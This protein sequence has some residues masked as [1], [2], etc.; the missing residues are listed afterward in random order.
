MASNGQTEKK[1][2]LTVR[3]VVSV[4]LW[5]PLNYSVPEEMRSKVKIGQRALVPLNKRNVTGIIVDVISRDRC[6]TEIK[7]MKL[8]PIGEILDEQPAADRRLIKLTKWMTEYYVNRWERNLQLCLPRGNEKLIIKKI[9]ATEKLKGSTF[10]KSQDYKKLNPAQKQII[11]YLIS[12]GSTNIKI[13]DEKFGK[14]NWGSILQSLEKRGYVRL[15]WSLKSNQDLE[16]LNTFVKINDKLDASGSI[17]LNL[18]TKMWNIL[19]FLEKLGGEAPVST[20]SREFKNVYSTIN[21]LANKG[22]IVKEKRRIFRRPALPSQSLLK[23]LGKELLVEQQAAYAAIKR[24]L[25]SDKYSSFLLFG[26][27]GSGKTEIYLQVI[28]E[29]LRQN[30]QA[31]V[32]VPEIALTPQIIRRFTGRFGSRIAVI[33][34]R[35]SR[36]EKYDEWE[37][38]RKGEADIVIGARSALFAPLRNPGIIIVDEEQ[39][40]SYKQNSEPRYNARDLAVMRAYQNRCCVLLGS[41]TPSVESYYNG[42]TGKYTMLKLE[43]RVNERP[44]PDIRIIDM[45]KS[46]KKSKKQRSSLSQEMKAAMMKT[47]EQKGQIILLLNRRGYSTHIYCRHC[48]EGISCPHCSV[49]M[50]YHSNENKIMCHHCLYTSPAPTK[51]PRCSEELLEYRGMGIQK[52]EQE[53]NELFPSNTVLRM[54][55]DTVT[56]KNAYSDILDEFRH[57]KADIL[58]GTQMVAKGHDFAGVLLVG[59]LD[60]DIGLG[61]PN[62]RS[63]EQLFALLTQTAGR[64]GRGDRPG[65]CLIQTLCPDHYSVQFAQ[66]H[67]YKGFYDAELSLRKKLHMPPFSSLTL[68][69]LQSSNRKLVHHT[70]YDLKSE[71]QKHSTNLAA[72]FGPAPAPVFKLK[73]DYRWQFLIKTASRKMM[74]SYLHAIQP[75][76][77]KLDK[78]RN[79]KLVID[80]DPMEVF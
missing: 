47:L 71:L 61:I 12:F 52:L 15:S 18:S 4:P 57:G 55:R 70:A 41:A 67:D 66:K 75:L 28:S 30:R 33:H 44:L 24:E 1:N 11:D 42:L 63:A 65:R 45:N 29:V 26:V 77:R 34:S 13:I 14:K 37:R 19:E 76:L 64:T 21:R 38:I 9:T 8:E 17:D 74:T 31:L 58:I 53:L 48:R 27:T 46:L 32:L 22:L 5:Q 25:V 68:I 78:K 51:C 43:K 72:L 73:D 60:A 54:D 59:I 3:V 62:F 16:K 56:S 6:E 40:R 7:K 20:L 39:D 49:S 10:K 69:R 79:I 80:R 23:T 50:V 35:L 36:G 2:S